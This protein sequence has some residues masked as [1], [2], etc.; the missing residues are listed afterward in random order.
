MGATR[1]NNSAPRCPDCGGYVTA[2]SRLSVSLVNPIPHIQAELGECDSCHLRVQRSD[3]GPW[4]VNLTPIDD[5]LDEPMD[6][7]IE[8]RI[9]AKNGRDWLGFVDR[10]RAG[11]ELWTLTPSFPDYVLI[12][13]V[14]RGMVKEIK[15]F[16]R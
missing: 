1:L 9:R 7:D 8:S 6:S 4:R 14:S 5:R 15:R 11:D 2:T 16:R 10:M 12:A 3:D 13:I